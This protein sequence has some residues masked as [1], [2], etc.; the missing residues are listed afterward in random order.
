MG[1]EKC[2]PDILPHAILGV[3]QPPSFE[4]E[5]VAQWKSLFCKQKIPGSILSI[6]S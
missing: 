5:A 3:R 6:P 4:G 1:L 2:I